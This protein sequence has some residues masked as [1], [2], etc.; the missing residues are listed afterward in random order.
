MSLNAMHRSIMIFSDSQ[1]KAEKRL[2]ELAET[3]DEEILVRRKDYIQ[4]P[5][6][7]FQARWFSESC[8]GYRYREAHVD[9]SLRNNERAME[10]IVMKL[11]PP[12]YYTDSPFDEKYNWRDHVHYFN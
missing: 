10:L 1:E 8:R 12:H 5:I 3:L 7:T 4:T 6:Q 11:V 2:N 9:N